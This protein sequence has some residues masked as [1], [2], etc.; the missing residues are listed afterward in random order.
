MAQFRLQ[1]LLLLLATGPCLPAAMTNCTLAHWL[2]NVVVE[3]SKCSPCSPL[4]PLVMSGNKVSPEENI[5]WTLKCSIIHHAWD[6]MVNTWRFHISN[7]AQCSMEGD[8]QGV[9]LAHLY[10]LWECLCHFPAGWH[11]RFHICGWLLICKHWKA[12]N[13]GFLNQARNMSPQYFRQLS[14]PMPYIV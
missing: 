11:L 2:S 8:N 7:V 4:F 3:A 14:K 10:F 5:E 9:H 1:R 13:K 12:T 6:V